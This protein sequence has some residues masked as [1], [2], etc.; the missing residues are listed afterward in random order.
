MLGELL[1]RV[2]AAQRLPGTVDVGVQQLRREESLDR[3]IRE[4]HRIGDRH[5][6]EDKS[7]QERRAGN[8][9]AMTRG[10]AAGPDPAEQRQHVAA[11]H[12]ADAETG[13]SGEHDRRDV[14]RTPE[15]QAQHDHA[16]E[17]VADDGCRQHALGLGDEGDPIGEWLQPGHGRQRLGAPVPGQVR[18]EQPVPPC[19]E[20]RQL[21]PVRRGPSQPVDE[22]QR[23][24]GSAHEIPHAHALHLG[25]ALLQTGQFC[26]RHPG[27]LSFDP[28]TDLGAPAR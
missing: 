11:P 21:G 5:E 20:R 8:A 2:V 15:R 1:P 13:C 14:V 26:V 25:E 18:D 22:D 19:Q 23:R 9:A 17:R 12:V 7:A 16:A 28:M 27:R 4:A 24:P 3:V 6:P 10:Y